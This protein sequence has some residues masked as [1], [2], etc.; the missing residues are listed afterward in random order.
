MN[1]G[2]HLQVLDLLPVAEVSS[3][4]NGTGVD[5]QQLSGEI[6]VIVDSSAATNGT[7]PTLDLSLEH[8]DSLGSGY[9]A[10]SGAAFAQITDSASVQKMSLNKDE[11]KR[12]VR[13]VKDIGGTDSPKFLVSAKLVGVKKY[14]A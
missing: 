3:D 1:L 4:G 6:A 2:D 13:I 14:P 5:T 8:S 11:L 9:A 10:I 7:S 12:Y